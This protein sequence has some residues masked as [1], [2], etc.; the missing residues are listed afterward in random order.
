MLARVRANGDRA[1]ERRER[2]EHR[3][4]TGYQPEPVEVAEQLG[5]T[6]RD[7]CDR[8][9]ASGL[10]ID[11]GLFG[12][13]QQLELPVGDRVAVRIV[14]GIPELGVDL[15]LELFGER[16]LEELGLRVNLVERKP[17]TV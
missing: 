10:H 17:E 6:V 12:T 13:V 2:D 15:R 1:A 14:G 16:M 11:Q 5:I 4:R 8:R 3:I 7:A 9:P